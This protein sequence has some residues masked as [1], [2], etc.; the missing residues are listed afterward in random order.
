MKKV[1]NILFLFIALFIFS[2]GN[3]QQQR[4]FL[5]GKITDAKTGM[6]LPGASIYIHD[7]NKGTTATDSG[8]FKTVAVIPNRY[9]VEISHTGYKN[10]VE[11]IS[12]GA[13][14]Q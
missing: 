6:P 2:F 4:A 7:I 1:I 11:R 5:T 3:G 8:V 10:I 12:I 9:L 14:A 13:Q